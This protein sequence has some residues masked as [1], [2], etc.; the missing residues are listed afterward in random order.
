MALMDGT[1]KQLVMLFMYGIISLCVVF[2]ACSCGDRL[3]KPATAK[4]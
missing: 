3:I 4:K 2:K 1:F